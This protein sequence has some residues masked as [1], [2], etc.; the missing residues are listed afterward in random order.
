M[1][2]IFGIAAGVA[3]GCV[4][5]WTVIHRTVI[6]ASNKGQPLPEPPAW[7]KACHPCMKG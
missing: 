3:V 4:V 7:H 1:K 6:A 5:C 2:K